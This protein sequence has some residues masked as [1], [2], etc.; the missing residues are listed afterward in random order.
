VSPQGTSNPRAVRLRVAE[1]IR[2]TEDAASLVLDVPAELAERFAYRPGQFLTIS[3]PASEG[4]VARCY[5]LSSSPHTGD[6]HA[7]TVKRAG[8]GSGWLV[9][10][11]RPGTELDVLPPAGLFTPGDLDTDLLLFAGGSGITPV[12]SIVKSALDQGRGTIVL[13]YTNRDEKSVIFADELRELARDNPRLLVIHWLD[14][15]QGHPTAAAMTA[16]ARPYAGFE[17]FVCGPDPYM[18]IVKE[19]LAGLGVPKRR[20]H[21]ERFLPLAENPFEDRP[22][23]SG[24]PQDGADRDG[25]DQ[26]GAD[27]DGADRDGGTSR[28]ATLEVTMDGEER[29]LAWP[30]GARML[31][32]LIDD[33]LDAPFSCREGNCGACACQVTAGEVKMVNNEV[34]EDE[35]IAEGYVLACQSLAVTE[36]VNITY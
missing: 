36:T 11:V 9:D 33:G 20:V 16:L 8:Y 17:A 7:I 32:V 24:A 25:A 15:V 31:D 30:A 6:Q 21:I 18:K 14:S 35:D 12:M 1:V 23:A 13:V 26:D 2:Q 28:P 3:V 10:N 34:L 19:A 5:S 27:Q 4:P 22:R 29:A